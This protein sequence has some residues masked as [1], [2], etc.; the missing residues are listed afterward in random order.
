MAAVLARAPVLMAAFDP[1]RTL[2]THLV[3]MRR[4][5]SDSADAGLKR[6]SD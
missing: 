2:A 6:Q 1:N 5:P 3:A 4:G